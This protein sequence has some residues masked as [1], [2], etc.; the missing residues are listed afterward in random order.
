MKTILFLSV[1]KGTA[2][3]VPVDNAALE[4]LPIG[5]GRVR[6]PQPLPFPLYYY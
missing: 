2:C 1:K 5:E 6:I 3:F 4:H